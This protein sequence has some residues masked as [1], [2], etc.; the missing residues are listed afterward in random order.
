VI[1]QRAHERDH[2]LFGVFLS[3]VDSTVTTNLR[4]EFQVTSF[5]HP[6]QKSARSEN[7]EKVVR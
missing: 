3:T 2:A 6:F 7:L 5:I 4:N 1:K